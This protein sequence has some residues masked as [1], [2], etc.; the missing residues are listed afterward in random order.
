MRAGHLFC[1]KRFFVDDLSGPAWVEHLFCK[2]GF[3]VGNLS[4]P[5]WAGNLFRKFSFFASR[6]SAFA[7]AVPFV[8]QIRVCRKRVCGFRLG[9]AVASRL[10]L[11]QAGVVSSLPRFAFNG[12]GWECTRLGS[13]E[14][15]LCSVYSIAHLVAVI[16][17]SE[18][19]GFRLR[20]KPG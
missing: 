4:G 12:N 11:G 1:K 18:R 19:F 13:S 2:K 14:K 9:P 17:M 6:G 20:Q 5:A 10:G 3:F 16:A 8:L 7:R 15:N